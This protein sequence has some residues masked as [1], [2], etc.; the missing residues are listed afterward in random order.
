[1]CGGGGSGGGGGGGGGGGI[2][3]HSLLC[4]LA[5]LVLVNCSISSN[6]VIFVCCHTNS[7]WHQI[8]MH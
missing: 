6:C 5:I 4:I 7:L 8:I 3:R 1:M 2:P